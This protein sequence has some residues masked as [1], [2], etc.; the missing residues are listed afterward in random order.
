MNLIKVLPI[1]ILLFTATAEAGQIY[2]ARIIDVRVDRSGKGLVRFDRELESPADCI[3]QHLSHLSFD[4]NTFSGQNLLNLA[5]SAQASK[6]KVQAWGTNTCEEWPSTVESWSHGWLVKPCNEL[7]S[8]CE[9]PELNVQW[10]PAVITIGQAA[11]LHVTAYNVSYC[12]GDSGVK[13]GT[14]WVAPDNYEMADRTVSISCYD[15]SDKEVITQTATLTVNE[16]PQLNVTWQPSSIIKGE[17]AQV[18]VNASNV[19]YCKGDSGVRKG[20][21]WISAPEYL[22]ENRTVTIRCYDLS[23]K[24]IVSQSATLT[25]NEPPQL[26]VTWQP[27]SIIKGESAQVHVNASNVNYCKGDS[28]VRKGT[29]WISAPEYLQENRTVTIRC[30]DLNDKEIV[31]QSATLTVNEPPQLNVTWQPS[32][33]IK[34]ES[35]QVHVN[36][37]NVNYCKG[38]SGVRKGT[39][40]ISAPEYSQQSRT[41]TIRCYNKNDQEVISKQA[42]LTVKQPYLSVSWQPSTVKQGQGARA[43]ITAQNVSYCRGDSGVAKGTSWVS[44]IVYEQATR[45]ITIRCYNTKDQEVIS[46]QATLNV[47]K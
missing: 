47:R 38:D 21:S 9:R 10:K 36:A 5:L 40:W 12:L 33:I 42:R 26:N 46:R 16:P 37:S 7:N 39:S 3:N 25:V 14:H 17:S 28:G 20:T 8:N 24:E 11:D 41:V 34:G 15:T 4:L 19:N 1:I 27:S 44:P 30:Y 43:Y 29:S 18:H 13:K 35:A 2:G 6:S 31:S 45:T 32:S 22:Q 23:D